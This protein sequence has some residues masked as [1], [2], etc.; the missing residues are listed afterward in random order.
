[1]TIYTKFNI[2]DTIITNSNRKG[3]IKSLSLNND[4]Y[5]VKIMDTNEEEWYSENNLNILIGDMYLTE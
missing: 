3:I 5:L 1:M 2:G 4:K